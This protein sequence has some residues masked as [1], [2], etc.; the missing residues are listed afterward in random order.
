[1][2]IDRSHSYIRVTITKNKLDEQIRIK[3][4]WKGCE[5]LK[6]SILTCKFLQL[7]LYLPMVSHIYVAAPRCDDYR[8]PM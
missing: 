5:I 6:A 3:K 8:V 7:E 2:K 1:M 4:C